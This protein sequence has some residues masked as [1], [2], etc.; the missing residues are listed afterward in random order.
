MT[1]RL[2]WS[3]ER[4][5]ASALAFRFGF[6]LRAESQSERQVRAGMPL[7]LD[8]QP[9]IEKGQRQAGLRRECLRQLRKIRVGIAAGKKI[10]V[11]TTLVESIERLRV[12][13]SNGIGSVRQHPPMNWSEV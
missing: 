2:K 8:I 5:Q 1:H 12:Q 3:C 4:G 13:L 7:I 10:R 9:K 6:M 11:H